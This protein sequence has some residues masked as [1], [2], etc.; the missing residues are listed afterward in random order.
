MVSYNKINGFHVGI[1]SY[2]QGIGNWLQLMVQNGIPFTAK[3]VDNTGSLM[4]AQPLIQ[5]GNKGYAIWRNY[6]I[7]GQEQGDN[8]NYQNTPAQEADRYWQ[9]AITM[10][11]PELDKETVWIELI[12]EPDKNKADWL[13][14]VAFLLGQKALAAGY[15]LLCFGWSS[16][17]PEPADWLTNGM[18]KYLSLCSSNPDK[19]GISV[20]EY[21]FDVTKTLMDNYPWQIGRYQNIHRACDTFGFNY[22]TIFLTEFGWSYQQIPPTQSAIEQIITARDVYAPSNVKGASIWALDSASGWGNIAQQVHELMWLDGVTGGTSP[23]YQAIRDY[24]ITTP[25][26]PT[27]HKA[28]VVKLPQEATASDWNTM[29][30]YAYQY[31]HTLTASHDD[32]LYILK[33]G[34]NESY[35]KIYKPSLPSQQGFIALLNEDN[36]GWVAVG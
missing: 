4:D 15:K 5:A 27:K 11:P 3:A 28:I 1:P 9:S 16:G 13:G 24:P 21:Q 26:P 36:I 23:L 19:L 33:S 17:E 20:H 32:A 35:A 6:N 7:N 18:R 31:K 14:E 8:P 30:A 25:P 29:T 34:N 22:P 12:N 2:S 10:Y